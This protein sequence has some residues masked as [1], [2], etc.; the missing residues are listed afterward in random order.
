ML[1][2]IGVLRWVLV[3]GVVCGQLSEARE[4][5]VVTAFGAKAIIVYL[6]TSTPIDIIN[7]LQLL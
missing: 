7:K 6:P 4:Q 5:D 1:Q 2:S 3:G